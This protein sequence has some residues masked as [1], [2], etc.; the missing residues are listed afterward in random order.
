[1]IW[2]VVLAATLWGAPT[3]TGSEEP[4]CIWGGAVPRLVILAG[5][6]LLT[7]TTLDSWKSDREWPPDDEDRRTGQPKGQVVRVRTASG[8][9]AA[10][11]GEGVNVVVVRWGVYDDCSWHPFRDTLPV[12][13]TQHFR[14]RLR[15]DSLWVDGAPTLDVV[16]NPLTEFPGR[17]ESRAS[18][19][20][21]TYL[22]F[23]SALPDSASWVRDCRPPTLEVTTWL[24]RH[25]EL[26]N[27]RP[28][29]WGDDLIESCNQDLEFRA[30]DF[31]LWAWDDSTW[32]RLLQWRESGGCDL[33]SERP[34]QLDEAAHGAFVA[35]DAEQWAIK[36]VLRDSWQ[37]AVV[38]LE[39]TPRV[40]ELARMA[41]DGRDWTVV[42]AHPEY[43]S[44][45]SAREFQSISPLRRPERDA[46]LILGTDRELGWYESEQGWHSLRIRCCTWPGE[47]DP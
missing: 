38:V 19:P 47:M 30:D 42:V 9:G 6:T 23:I 29:F 4:I 26:Q 20:F 15:P 21:D 22:D 34:G 2:A 11:L 1:M 44:W 3:L 37:L 32:A 14:G 41:G 36:C 45:M 25:P 46:I 17:D 28:F 40:V 16:P 10:S 27:R 18:V 5:E 7:G 12:G 13:T 24:A 33:L 31:T 8:L 35:S 43:F 39:A